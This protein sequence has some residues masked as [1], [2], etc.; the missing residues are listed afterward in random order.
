MASPLLIF[1]FTFPNDWKQFQPCEDYR[2][3]ASI[4]LEHDR[5]D[6][7]SGN[8][9]QIHDIRVL[10][11]SQ[12]LIPKYGDVVGIWR[13]YAEPNVRITGRAIESNH[14]IA[15]MASEEMLE[16]ILAFVPVHA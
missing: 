12:G 4:D 2:A 11:G 9:L 6:R 15:E 7:E 5:A 3:A 10:W 13:E 14:Y 1:R 16:E 8:K